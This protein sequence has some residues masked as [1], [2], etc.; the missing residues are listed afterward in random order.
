MWICDDDVTGSADEPEV[1]AGNDTS[2]KPPGSPTSSFQGCQMVY[3]QTKD[4]N[5][6]GEPLWLSGL[7]V[8]NRKINEIERTRVRS[9]PQ[10]TFF[11]N[12]R[13]QFRSILEGFS[14]EDVD[15]FY[16]HLVNF[17]V[18]WFI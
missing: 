6:G 1:L 11:S 12:Q 4:P 8:K 5:L 7:V 18:I 2:K 9:P 17:T 13:S 16:E 14:M 3:F 15:I 10:A